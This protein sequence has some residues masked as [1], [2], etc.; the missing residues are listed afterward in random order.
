MM[1]IVSGVGALIVGYSIG[2][3]DKV[4]E[5]RR[6]FAYMAFFVFSMLLLVEGGNLLMLLAA[7][8]L[9]GLSSY[10]LIGFEHERPAAV[11]A[12]KKAFIMNAFGD[13]TF[14]LALFL[15][16]QQTGT[17]EYEAV[18]AEVDGLSS[19]VATLVALGLLGGAVAK[20][21]QLP[22]QTWLPDAM[23]GPTPVSALIHAATMVVAGVYLIFR[24]APIFEAAPEVQDTAA[25]LGAL[26]LVAAGLIA[27]VQTDIKR[28]IAYSTMS[29]IGYMFLAVGIGAYATGMF[30]LLTHAFF[31]ALLFLAAGILIHALAGEQDLRQMGGLRRLMPFTYVAFL[32]GSLALVGVPPFSGFFS[33]DPILANALD[34]GDLGY[35]L[36]A[37]AAAGAFLTGLYTFRMIFLAFG[38]EPS[39]ELEARYHPHGGKE[40]PPSMVLVV[41]VLDRALR[42]RRLPPVRALLDAGRRLPRPGGGAARPR[43]ERPGDVREH[44]RRR[45]SASPASPSP[46]SCTRRRSTRRR[47]RGRRSRRSSTSTGSTTRSS[48]G[49]PSR[50]RSSCTPSSK[51]R[52]SAARSTG[53]ATRHG[54]AR[55]Y[56][57]ALQTGIVRTYVLAVAAGLA[58]LVLVF[59]SVRAWVAGCQ[60][61]DRRCRSARRSRS[62]SCR[63]R[64]WPPGSIALVVS[65]AEVGLWIAALVDFD[66]SQ[67][68]STLQYEEQAT[69][70]G[71]LGISYHVGFLG[72]G[73]WLAGLAVVCQAAAVAYA[74]RAGRERPRAYFGLMLLLTGA[75]V[76]VFCAQDLLLFYVFWEAMLIPLYLLVGVWGGEGRQRATLL[77][78]IYTMAGSLLMLASIIVFGLSEGTFDLTQLRTEGSSTWLFLGFVVAF[79]VK[80]P[81]FPFHGW[82]PSAYREAPAEVAGVLSGVVSKAAAYGFLY[83]AIVL[84]PGPGGRPP[85]ADP[86]VRRDRPRL[87]LAAR[88]PC[89]RHPRRHRVLEPRPARR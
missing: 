62:G 87:R 41:G 38:G 26:T 15:L 31:K 60:R 82:L 22:L 56:V 24:T 65:L 28:V 59:I 20:S 66:F 8:G 4:D 69:W 23:E 58:V 84:F 29:Q 33:K 3:M 32:V 53:I 35:V 70:F 63:G 88:V 40:G 14:A 49:P 78:V 57:R 71:D 16:I 36:F 74:M 83:I 64:A 18:F 43:D 34:A 52:S 46:G 80:A 6:F 44:R 13:A 39:E 5:E 10:L 12:A 77:F 37:L 81:L 54:P 2:Y 76:G 61:A 11:A 85:R 45:R 50:R 51:G 47:G 79:A 42:R 27:L 73:L 72:I 67:A 30:H 89:A 1:L 68:G 75:I 19:T 7:W 48:T 55:G 86:R 21:A 17:L 25:I 9:V